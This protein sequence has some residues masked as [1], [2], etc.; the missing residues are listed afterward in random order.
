MVLMAELHRLDD[1]DH[2]VRDPGRAAECQEEP[3][4]STQRDEHKHEAHPGQ[5]VG[6][7]M[8]DL[9]HV[10]RPPSPRKHPPPNGLGQTPVPVTV[11]QVPGGSFVVARA[12][13]TP[14]KGAQ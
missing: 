2:R 4:P 6:T 13:R 1:G 12:G 14:I 10:I 11:T 8:E 3:K 5:G 7:A 9:R